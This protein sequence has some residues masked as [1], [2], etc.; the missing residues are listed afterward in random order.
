MYRHFIGVFHD[1]IYA[2]W[3]VVN[4]ANLLARLEGDPDDYE[5]YALGAALCASTIAQL[6]LPEHTLS[7]DATSSARFAQDCLHM[8]DLYDY[9]E[10]YSLTSSIL[11]PFFLHAYYANSGKPRT[12]G[13]FLREALTY[14]HAL[15][16]GR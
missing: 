9:R 14:V 8:R 3:P 11:T 12:A 6:R 15:E 2:I 13:Y 7:C 4:Y 5:A 1:R 16:L 10:T